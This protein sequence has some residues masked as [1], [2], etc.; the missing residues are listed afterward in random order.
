MKSAIT[1]ALILLGAICL[2]VGGYKCGFHEGRHPK[3]SIVIV[4]AI[5]NCQARLD[6][7]ENTSYAPCWVAGR[8]LIENHVSNITW[9]PT[10]KSLQEHP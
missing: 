4:Y 1:Y 3:N 7:V 10:I 8:V 6:C 5:T 2:W 9:N